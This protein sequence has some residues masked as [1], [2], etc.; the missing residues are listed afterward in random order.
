MSSRHAAYGLLACALLGLTAGCGSSNAAEGPNGP[1]AADPPDMRVGSCHRMTQPEE[2]YNGSD[3][4]P[5]VPCNQPH[6]TETYMVTKFTGELAAQR[7]RPSPEQLSAAIGKTC[8][9]RPIRPYL[10]AGPRDGQW[11]IGVWGKFPT[12]EEWAAGDRTLRCDLLVPTLA[13]AHG[14]EIAVPLRNIMRREDSALVRRCRFRGTDTIC[15][16]PHDAEWLEPALALP[17]KAYPGAA[18]ADRRAEQL[19]TAH[20]RTFVQGP[21]TGLKVTFDPVTKQTWDSGNRQLGCWLGRKDGTP[22]MGTLRGGLKA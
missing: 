18:A 16:R 15:A 6:Q 22:A 19:C 17:W 3:V 1:G 14:P 4:A 10:G 21:L 11:G 13:D 20:A 5:A 8:D 2:L 12:R 7:E 9:Y